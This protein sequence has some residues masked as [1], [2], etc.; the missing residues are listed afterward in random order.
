MK[1]G[2]MD[3]IRKKGEL[4]ESFFHKKPFNFNCTQSI[5]KSFQ[6]ENKFNDELIMDNSRM[7]GGR[8]PE[9]Q[10]GAYYAA[11][12][13][14]K[15]NTDHQT[16]LDTAFLKEM[17][18]VYCRDIRPNKIVPCQQIVKL[19]AEFIENILKTKKQ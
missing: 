3:S 7:G 2:T 18:S 15:D 8:A 1:P 14:L 13:V 11:R 10:C 9:G 12:L 5:M 19:T 6:E 17:K 4:A 16:Q